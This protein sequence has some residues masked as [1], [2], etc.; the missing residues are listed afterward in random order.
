VQAE[1]LSRGQLPRELSAQEEA[2]IQ[3]F[4]KAE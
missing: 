2:D 4:G 3:A 1:K